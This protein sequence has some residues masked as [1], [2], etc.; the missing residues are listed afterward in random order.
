MLLIPLTVPSPVIPLERAKLHCKITG[1]DRD[2]EVLDAVEAARAWA[3]LIL[4]RP[5]GETQQLEAIFERWGGYGALPFVPYSVDAVTANGQVATFG[6]AGRV[7]TA[8]GPA[9]VSVK[10]T[11]KGFT[12]ETLPAPIR[13]GMLLIVGDLVH[14]Q[15]GQ[16][17]VQL[18]ENR[19]AR[20]LMWPYREGLGI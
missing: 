20:D 16:V 8:A 18:Y 5:I 12:A 17:E 14:N 19:A 2:A 11:A 9:P 4:Q 15:Q 10:F 3:Q 6:A 13:F 1:A 7:I